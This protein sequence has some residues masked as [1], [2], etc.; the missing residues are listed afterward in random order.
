MDRDELKKKLTD[1]EYRVTQ[2]KGTE[3]PFAN[4]YWNNDERGMYAC[5]VCGQI[6]FASDAKLDSSTGPSGLQGWPA[7]DQAIPE[8]V[9]YREDDSM[10][11]HRIE[12]ICSRCKSHLG[13]IFED[14]TKTGKHLCINSCALS[15]EKKE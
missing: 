5:K 7:F 12:A 11:M 10:G 3:K 6:L 13:H 1:E 9:E 4:A 14:D 15:F 8:T 2:E